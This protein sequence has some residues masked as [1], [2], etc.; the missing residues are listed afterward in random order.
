MR[1]TRALKQVLERSLSGLDDS[2]SA[3]EFERRQSLED[4]E[5]YLVAGKQWAGSLGDQFENKPRFEFNKVHLSVIRLFNEYRNNPIAVDFVAKDEAQ[6]DELSDACDMLLRADEQDSNA[7]EAYDNAFEES[8]AGGMGG[9]RLCAKYEDEGDEENEKQRIHIMPIFEA[10]QCLYFDVN[11]KRQD[12]ADAE[13]AWLLTSMHPETYKEKYKKD[14]SSVDKRAADGFSWEASEVVYV[15]EYYE[16]EDQGYTVFEYESLTGEQKRFTEDDFEEDEEGESNLRQELED[17]GWTLKKT[18]K[19]TRKRV[20]KYIHDGAEILE[21]CGFIAGECIPLIPQYG[22]RAYV[23]GVERFSG[24]VRLAKDPQRLKNMQISKLAEYAAMSSME[25]PILTPEQVAGHVHMWQDDNIQQYPFL[26]INPITDAMGQKLPAGPVA[27]TK[28]PSIPPAMSALL[29]GTEFD[30]KEILGSAQLGEKME[31]NQSGKAVE[32]IQN[33]IDM[34]AFIY[35][36]NAAKARKRGAEVWLSMAKELYAEKGRKMR[37]LTKDQKPQAIELG[38]EILQEGK[39][40]S[41]VDMSRAKLDVATTVGPASSSRKAATVRALSNTAMLVQD[42]NE[43]AAIIGTMMLNLEGEGLQD[44]REYYRKRMVQMGAAKPTDDDKRE[45]EEAKKTAQPDPNAELVKAAAQREAAEAANAE[46][47][48]LLKVEKMVLTQAQTI[49]TL[50]KVG[51]ME[52]AQAIQAM[53]ALQAQNQPQQT[54]PVQGN[55][56]QAAPMPETGA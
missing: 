21:D 3:S 24:H 51:E 55:A 19:I 49:E 23:N 14:I 30:L 2:Y 9:F 54:P 36:S 39:V 7:E 6:N 43:R 25:K 17:S 27:Y 35:T 1:Q 5:F 48:A 32:L 26:L 46:A 44:L 40:I 50:S 22:K 29:Q 28:P 38:R 11:A 13:R 47:D 37:G 15:A 45:A 33:K 52:Q 20:H 53:E 16:I 31:A 8:T 41:E 56:N 10:D 42:P 4:R 34:Q 18:R 12:K